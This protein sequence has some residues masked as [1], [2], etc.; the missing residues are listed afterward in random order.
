MNSHLF[1]YNI[2]ENEYNKKVI[3][4]IIYDEKKAYCKYI[5][6]LYF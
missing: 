4:D 1:K 2:S 3:N 6:R 5:K